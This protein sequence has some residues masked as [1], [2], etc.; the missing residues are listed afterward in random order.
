[1]VQ[2]PDYDNRAT[3]IALAPGNA[4]KRL[5]SKYSLAMKNAIGF[6]VTDAEADT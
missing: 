6:V 2:E 1:M 3:A 5:C 4:A